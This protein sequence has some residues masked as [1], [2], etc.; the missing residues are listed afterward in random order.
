VLFWIVGWMLLSIAVAGL[1]RSL[2]VPLATAAVT[3]Y[4]AFYVVLTEWTLRRQPNLLMNPRAFLALLYDVAAAASAWALLFWARFNFNIDGAEFTAGDVARSL[5]FVVPVH[6]LVF[7]GLGLYEGLW[8]FAS[9]A[10][11]RRIVLG[12]FVAAASTAVLFVIVRP[13]ALSGRDPCCC[14]SPHC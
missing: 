11:L 8:R 13:T 12:A 14:C 7:V 4:A 6:A 1:V 2:A 5:A 3:A 9:M 10:D